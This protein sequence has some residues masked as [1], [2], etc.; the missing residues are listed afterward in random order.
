MTIPHPNIYD[1]IGC[2]RGKQSRREIVLVLM[3]ALQIVKKSS[4]RTD[5]RIIAITE[6][7]ENSPIV[8]ILI[9]NTVQINKLNYLIRSHV[10][11]YPVIQS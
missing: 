10:L 1:F 3:E 7:G 5:E 8:W 2:L 11:S 9:S 6:F 4:K